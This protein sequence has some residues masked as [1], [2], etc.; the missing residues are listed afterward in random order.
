MEGYHGQNRCNHRR[1][2]CPN[3][4]EEAGAYDINAYGLAL[5]VAHA[6]AAAKTGCRR[7]YE[8]RCQRSPAGMRNIGQGHG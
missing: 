5:A 8:P 3:I 2:S 7:Q 6:A 1:R 4:A